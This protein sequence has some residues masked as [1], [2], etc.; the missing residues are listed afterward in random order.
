MYISWIFSRPAAHAMSF[1]RHFVVRRIHHLISL[2]PGLKLLVEDDGGDLSQ[3]R[4]QP[5]SPIF[6]VALEFERICRTRHYSVQT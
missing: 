5:A 3:I 1:L 2:K 4:T 6:E